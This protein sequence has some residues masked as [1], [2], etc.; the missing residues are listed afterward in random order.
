MSAKRANLLKDE[1]GAA[2]LEFT[3]AAFTFF[4]IL[5]G[6][7]EFALVFFQWNLATK[8][9]QVGARLAAVSSPVAGTL[10]TLTGVGGAV[11]PGD[12]M[13]AFDYVCTTTDATGATGSCTNTGVYNAAAKQ[14]IF[15]GRGNG[16]TCS[17]AG[18]N[19]V[20]VC[21][22]IGALT[23]QNGNTPTPKN[24]SIEYIYTGLGYAGRPGAIDGTAGPV[25]TITVSITGI[26]HNF[27]LVKGLA[28]I[29]SI[30]LPPFATTVTGEDLATAGS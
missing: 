18:T 30:S 13:P 20:G 8:A 11:L 26:T 19:N 17:G 24:I 12:P 3:A 29:T 22:F 10:N 4:I 27:F 15:Y 2:M 14:T 16:T 1:S 5:Y 9:T 23:D 6:V 25:P 21:N 7:I 28:G